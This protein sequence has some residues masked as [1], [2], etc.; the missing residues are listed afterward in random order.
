MKNIKYINNKIIKKNN[1]IYISTL[2]DGDLI[3]GRG[4]TIFSAFQD[5]KDIINCLEAEKSGKFD[6]IEEW[7]IL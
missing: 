4:E 1:K 2:Y 7:I 6:P 3:W 5:I